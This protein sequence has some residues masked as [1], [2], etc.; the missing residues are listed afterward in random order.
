[1]DTKAKLLLAGLALV[2]LAFMVVY[3]LLAILAGPSCC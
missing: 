3:G 1:M 2:V